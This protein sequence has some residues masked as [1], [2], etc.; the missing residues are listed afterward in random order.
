M[1]CNPAGPRPRCG[2][3][4]RGRPAEG[5]RCRGSRVVATRGLLRNLSALRPSEPRRFEQRELLR[6]LL[7]GC[8]AGAGVFSTDSRHC[9]RQQHSIE[10][11]C[12]R[13]IS[14]VR[15]PAMLRKRSTFL[16]PKSSG[17]SG[18]FFA[19]APH[20]LLRQE[21]EK[22]P[23]GLVRAFE[24]AAEFGQKPCIFARTAQAVSS[25]DRRWE[26][27][28]TWAA[29]RLRREADRAEPQ[30]LAFPAFR[31]TELCDRSRSE[32][33]R[34]GPPRNAFRCRPALKFLASRISP[35]QSLIA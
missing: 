6:S 17:R 12:V 26:D 25:P 4:A 2:D 34:G 9:G 33:G 32:T 23:I 8:G 3:A 28:S 21:E 7:A 20:H 15:A 18:V 29:S 22:L 5:R 14:A 10:D 24:E 1:V 31:W 35:Q 27:G 16:T 13:E 30:G 11:P 19:L